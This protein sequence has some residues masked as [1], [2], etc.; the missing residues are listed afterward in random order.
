MNLYVSNDSNDGLKSLSLSLNSSRNRPLEYGKWSFFRSSAI[1]SDLITSFFCPRKCHS[2]HDN[3][4]SVERSAGWSAGWLVGRWV[5][6]S[7]H[8]LPGFHVATGMI[9]GRWYRRT[10]HITTM[11]R[12]FPPLPQSTCSSAYFYSIEYFNEGSVSWLSSPQSN[13]Y[14]LLFFYKHA[15]L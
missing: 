1:L 4:L 2:V 14:T 12:S 9:K 15:R 10:L 5:P 6:W 13:M 8:I 7:E 11:G 3:Y